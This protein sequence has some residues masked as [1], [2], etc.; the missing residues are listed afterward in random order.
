MG[1]VQSCSL[2]LRDGSGAGA[3]SWSLRYMPLP[4]ELLPEPLPPNTGTP[5]EPP[6]VLL[7]VG[8]EAGADEE[9]PIAAPRALGA[10]AVARKNPIALT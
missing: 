7:I 4:P 2:I 8:V 3:G 9:R 1:L 6:V 5:V 10:T